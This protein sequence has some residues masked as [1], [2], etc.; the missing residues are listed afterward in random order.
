[1]ATVVL[2]FASGGANTRFSEGLERQRAQQRR[3]GHKPTL[4]PAPAATAKAALSSVALLLPQSQAI[5][6]EHN[7][8]N[9]RVTM[10]ASDSMMNLGVWPAYWVIF[11]CYLSSCRSWW[12]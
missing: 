12:M 1:M 6:P 10:V 4:A 7:R 11:V 5:T 3:P 8:K 2:M 9:R